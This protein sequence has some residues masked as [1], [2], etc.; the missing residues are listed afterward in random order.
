MA[1]EI[2][3]REGWDPDARGLFGAPPVAVIVSDEVHVSVLKALGLLGFGRER[4]KRVPTDAQGRMRTRNLPHLDGPTIICIQAGNVNT[5]AF[6]PAEAVCA[7]AEAKAW[8]HV[9]GAFGLWARAAPA[10]APLAI[11]F[12]LADSWAID[13]HKWLNLPYDCG[14]AFVRD[15]EALRGAMAAS[16]AYTQLVAGEREPCHYTPEFSRRAR[17]IEAWA[18][19]RQ[20]GRAGVADLVERTCTLAAY[21]AQR[22][23]AAGYEILNHVVINQVLVSFGS[24]ERTR[25]VIELVQRD[26]TCWCGGTEWQGRVAM[27]LSVSG[28][29]T[30]E[31][32]IDRSVD[33][34]VRI[35]DAEG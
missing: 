2:L 15:G 3:L 33:A 19:L 6:D 28:H 12:E 32:D 31:R 14:A 13:G 18:V 5:G 21:A 27:R 26:G 23:G 17:G 24:P 30:T 8:V 7:A 29:A 25:R 22:L 35:A 16:A 9:D 1:H 34:I 11:G 4:V 20:L 10:R